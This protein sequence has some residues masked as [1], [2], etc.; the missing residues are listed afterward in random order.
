[1]KKI[2][3]LALFASFIAV[4]GA[5]GARPADAQMMGGYYNGYG[6]GMMYSYYGSST[7]AAAGSTTMD[8]AEAAGQALAQKLRAG[9]IGCPTLT[10]ADYQSLGE[11]SMTLM[12]GSGH[13]AM[14]SYIVSRYGQAYDDSMH[15]AMGERFSGCG[16]ASAFA[17]STGFGPMMGGEHANG[18]GMMSGWGNGYGAPYGWDET[19]LAAITGALAVIGLFALIGWAVGFIKRR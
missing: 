12:M 4:A 11:Y 18:Y 7:P 5:L 2:A 14:D 9:T 19:I 17:G 10:Q 15:V 1:M 13:D 6:P 3:M 16:S 8:A